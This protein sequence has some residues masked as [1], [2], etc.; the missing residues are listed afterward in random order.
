MLRRWWLVPVA[1]VLAAA[2]VELIARSLFGTE[3]LEQ[4]LSRAAASSTGGLYRV[5]LG[6]ARFSL[7]GRSFSA[8]E[9]RFGPD[10]AVVE[11]R[12]RSGDAPRRLFAATS[13]S[14]HF[15][16]L[17]PLAMLR[18]DL[19]V[20]SVTVTD[21]RFEISLD[22]TV[23]LANPGA[24]STMPHELLRAMG[25]RLR[26]DQ[27]VVKQG[28]VG[29][30]EK[31][32]DGA[33]PGTIRFEEIEA[34]F[35]DVTNDPKVQAKQP[36]TAD[37]R[38][39]LA[40]KGPMALSLRYDLSSPQLKLDYQGTVG[41]MDGR[42]LNELRVNAGVLDTTWFDFRVRDGIATGQVQVLYHGLDSEVVDKVT[43]DRG[44]SEKYRTFL[45]NQLKV[46]DSNP[47]RAGEPAATISIRRVRTPE[48]GFIKFLWEN[49][50]VG[51]YE[52]LGA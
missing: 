48:T 3:A 28:S 46:D 44:F 4:R 26:I 20:A 32:T 19:V 2:L 37:L 29:Y 9:I 43:L 14:I 5:D 17:D 23:P 34:V 45:N 42:A 49:L 30:H 24:P 50:Q 25:H 27:F 16:G 40:A 39:L 22:R 1:A 12:R 31:D 10:S 33:R 13:P 21:P 35:R 52:T 38:F 15:A 18:G 11:E 6:A 36:C 7:L 51:V 47:P 8:S 41:T